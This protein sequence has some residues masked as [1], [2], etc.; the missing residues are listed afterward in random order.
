VFTTPCPGNNLVSHRPF[1]FLLSTVGYEVLQNSG[2]QTQVGT[3]PVQY[4]HTP[5]YSSRATYGN[6][7]RSYST[8]RIMLSL[9][10]VKEESIEALEKSSV[11][12]SYRQ[13]ERRIFETMCL[14]RPRPV[15]SANFR[16]PTIFFAQVQC[17]TVRWL[18]S[19]M[20]ISISLLP[21]Q[22]PYVS[23][24]GTPLGVK[25]QL[26][27]YSVISHITSQPGISDT[28]RTGRIF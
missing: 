27:F 12:H 5:N 10:K 22:C 15:P 20:L 18:S 13:Q 14:I 25:A 21:T 23:A 28:G 1:F 7:A 2:V 6:Q 3:I 19:Q 16:L 26:I 17:C 11:Q 8:W 24:Y 9:P 4:L